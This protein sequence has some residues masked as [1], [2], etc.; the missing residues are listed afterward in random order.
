MDTQHKWICPICGYMHISLHPPGRCPICSADGGLFSKE[1]EMPGPS[2]E[3]GD[4]AEPIA[5]QSADVSSAEYLAQ[6]QRPEYEL[7]EKFSTIQK[8]ARTGK[9]EI[10]P[11]GTRQKF[12]GFDT[13]LFRGTQ[14]ERFPLDENEKVDTTT[15]I[16]PEARHPLE[17]AMPFYVSHMSFGALSKEAK[18]ALAKGSSRAGTAIGSGEGGQLPEERANTTKYIYE[19]GTASFSYDERA[20]AGAEATEIKFGQA[21]KPGM[22]G[23]LPGEK[24]TAEIA[25]IRKLK[26]GQDFISPNRQPHIHSVEDLQKMIENIRAINGGRPVGVKFTAGHIEEDLRFVLA[27]RPDFITIDCR[28]GATGAAPAFIRDNLCLPPIYAIR[29]ARHYLDSVKSTVTLCVAGGFRDSTDIAKAIALGADCVALATASLIA[30][31]CQQYRIC[32]TGSC[33]VGIT[34]QDP[35]LRKRLNITI[36]AERLFNFFSVTNDELQT[37]ARINGRSAVR[38]LNGDDIFTISNEI[39]QNTDIPF[40]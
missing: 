28:G 38:D 32:N 19:I 37:L 3:Q 9:S 22:G 10:S 4:T 27:G 8:L 39:A 35:E 1:K 30:I 40:C 23:H 36:S 11:M 15:I 17:L 2:D 18:E 6:W 13:I 5:K 16:G 24:V 31:G 33:P 7:E 26:P 12:P 14:F 25:A 20:I 29:R 21:A 34:T